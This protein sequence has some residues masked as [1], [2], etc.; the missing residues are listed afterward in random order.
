MATSP[1]IQNRIT[2]YKIQVSIFSFSFQSFHGKLIFKPID[3]LTIKAS[4]FR[5][6]NAFN[7]T[8]IFLE[9]DLAST[10]EV[11]FETKAFNWSNTLVLNPAW[12]LK[13]GYS[14]S[15]YSNDYQFTL[16]NQTDDFTFLKP[17]R[18]KKTK[19]V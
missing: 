11:L 6:Y 19:V 9:E 17:Y 16:T 1:I 18:N 13:L 7:Y 2:K 12:S 15:N 8:S 5:T 14:N 3:K 4:W 10:D